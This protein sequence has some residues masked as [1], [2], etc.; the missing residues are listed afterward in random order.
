MV[1]VLVVCAPCGA[2]DPLD[3]VVGPR[4]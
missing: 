3:T 2:V 1:L 4:P